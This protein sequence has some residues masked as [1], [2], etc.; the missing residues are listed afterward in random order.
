MSQIVVLTCASG[1]QCR[2]II[3]LLLEQKGL[4]KLR[5]V[6]HSANSHATLVK[7]YADVEVVRADLDNSADCKRILHGATTLY[8]VSPPFQPHEVMYG[9][10]VID[11]AVA[12]SRRPDSK[13]SHFIFSSVLHPE[14]SKLLN[15][16][17]KRAIEEYLCESPLNYT[18]IQPSHFADNAM[19]RLLAQ[20]NSQNPVFAAA[21]DPEVAFSFSCLHDHAEASVKIIQEQS[22]HYFATYQLVSTLPM[23]YSDFIKSVGK[24]LGKEFEIKRMPFEETVQMYCNLVFG[25]EKVLDQ[26]FRDG[27]ERLLLYYNRRGLLG[28]PKVLEWLLGRPGT[29]PAELAKMLL[30][31]SQ[32]D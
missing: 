1:K 25:T 23:K 10:N 17:R 9:M 22:K 20:M 15:H 11:A 7:Q 14:I 5:L 27:P 30:G 18:V 32:G 2:H 8:Y 3:P 16:D 12:E 19:P 26:S 31:K 29:S 28:N 4:Y 6:V 21:H 24:A 13:F